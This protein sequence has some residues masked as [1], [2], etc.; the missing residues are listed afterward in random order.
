MEE[1]PVTS[2]SAVWS[3]LDKHKVCDGLY[4]TDDFI[5]LGREFGE[6]GVSKFSSFSA[7][8]RRVSMGFYGLPLPLLKAVKAFG[9]CG[10]LERFFANWGRGF[11]SSESA[12]IK[13]G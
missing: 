11:M 1:P 8:G 2:E 13:T 12:A 5:L 3:R 6:E 10:S 9:F 7:V 4:E